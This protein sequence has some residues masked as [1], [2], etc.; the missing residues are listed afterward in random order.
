[1]NLLN[2]VTI[3][4]RLWGA[5]ALMLLLF[6]AFGLFSLYEMRA[7]DRLT[8]E[9]YNHPF[10]VSNAALRAS[11]G[12]SNMQGSMRQAILARSDSEIAVAVQEVR[13]GERAAY[14][15]LEV[16]RNKILGAEGQRREKVKHSSAMIQP[17]RNERKAGKWNRLFLVKI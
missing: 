6:L 2:R 11:T 12:V 14:D 5:S 7:L 4:S 8:W 9:L 17:K 15:N 3:K 10:Q 13:E 1:M 16:V